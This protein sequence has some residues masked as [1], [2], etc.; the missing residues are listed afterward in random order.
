MV[1]QQS[2]SRQRFEAYNRSNL[3][4]FESNEGGFRNYFLQL[5]G[6]E[7][8]ARQ[9]LAPAGVAIGA[10]ARM[11]ELPVSTVRHY[12]RLGLVDPWL[13]AGRYHFDPVNL[14]QV[15]SV[16]QWQSLGLSLEEIQTRKAQ[17]PGILVRDILPLSGSEYLLDKALV[18]IGRSFET[19]GYLE[20][21]HISSLDIENMRLERAEWNPK[22][23]L[24][25]LLAEY[26]AVRERLEQKR[27]DLETRIAKV[28]DL[29]KQLARA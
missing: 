8:R 16:R 21:G 7:E 25:E 11:V 1:P 17:R 22:P 18:E 24:A 27:H 2:I 12:I 20:N 5:A 6:S 19:N 3:E 29:E 10:F 26:R 15:G 14:M 13:V 4:K 28:T 9:F 23:I